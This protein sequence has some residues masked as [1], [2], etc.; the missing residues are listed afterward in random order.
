MAATAPLPATGIWPA[1]E[2]LHLAKPLC[3]HPGLCAVFRL[4]PD[5]PLER[6]GEGQI[7]DHTEEKMGYLHCLKVP[8]VDLLQAA[9]LRPLARALTR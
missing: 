4:V 7:L 6:G 3:D 8:A 9:A 1:G 5:R 2:D